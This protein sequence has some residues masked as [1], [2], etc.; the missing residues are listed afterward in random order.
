MLQIL[1]EAYVNVKKGL[2]EDGSDCVKIDMRS[3]WVGVDGRM[4]GSASIV[5]WVSSEWY[6]TFGDHR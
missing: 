4:G 6:F 1:G 2:P 5:G 3:S